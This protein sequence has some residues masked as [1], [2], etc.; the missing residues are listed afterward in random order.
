V[1]SYKECGGE[2]STKAAACPKCGAKVQ[3]TS[4]LAAGCLTVL[5]VFVVLSLIGVLLGDGSSFS[6]APMTP[7]APASGTATGGQERSSQFS[8]LTQAQ[9]NAARSAQSYL[10]MSGF[11]RQGLIDQ[12]SSEYGDRYSVSDATVA[13]DNLDVDWN[14]QAAR[15][16]AAY[17]QMSGFSCQGLIDQLSS[18]YGD[19]YT[20]E[21]ARYGATR[22]G[23]C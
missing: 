4:I 21:Q 23:A 18:S 11:S 3:R 16:A 12:L 10:S 1:R 2:L 5:A 13:V 22:A 15:S 19:K 6:R 17:L 8:N 7:S 14:A 9:R 20:V